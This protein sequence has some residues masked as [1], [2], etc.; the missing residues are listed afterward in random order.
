MSTEAWIPSDNEVYCYLKLHLPAPFTVESEPSTS[1]FSESQFCYRVLD[2][3]KNEV[4]RLSGS[5]DDLQP[6]ML[7]EQ[8]KSLLHEL[9]TVS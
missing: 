9:R 8:A 6:G 4:K 5:Y 2:A 3:E 1:Y 7:V